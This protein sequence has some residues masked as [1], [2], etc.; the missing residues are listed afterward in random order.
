MAADVSR[1]RPLTRTARLLQIDTPEPGGPYRD[2]E[3]FG[4]EAA[5]RL[6]EL[7]PVGSVGY[8]EVDRELR[9]DYD[10]TLLYLFLNDG[11]DPLM[12]NLRLVR[13]GYAESLLVAPNDRHIDRIRAA[14]RQGEAQ[15]LGLWGAC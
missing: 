11:G 5:Q 12:V 2:E 6:A 9:D 10:R 14:E 8:A 4:R 1:A 15:G 7:M 3:C 13:E